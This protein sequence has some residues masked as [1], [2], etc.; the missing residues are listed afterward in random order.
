M[1]AN[2]TVNKPVLGIRHRNKHLQE[3]D[4]GS[5]LVGSSDGDTLNPVVNILMLD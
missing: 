2:Q 5:Y 1:P 4:H 3:R